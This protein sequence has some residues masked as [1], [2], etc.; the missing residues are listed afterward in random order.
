MY[1]G[2]DEPGVPSTHRM[3][4]AVGS[5]FFIAPEVFSRRYN[6][7]CDIWSLGINLYLLLSGTVPFG[8][9]VRGM[10]HPLQYC[11]WRTIGSQCS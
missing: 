4:Q 2:S 3:L 6:L 8:A 9:N 7:A 11:E 1:V 10:L 5:A